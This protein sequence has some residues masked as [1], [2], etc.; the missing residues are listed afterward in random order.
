MAGKP[1]TQEMKD[2]AK[3]K[4]EAAGTAAKPRPPRATRPRARAGKDPVAEAVETIL[5][6]LSLPLMALGAANDVFLADALALEM[7]AAPL[8]EAMAEVAK[9]NPAIG[10]WL[11]KGAPATPYILLGTVLFSLGTQIAVNHGANLGPLAAQTN[12]RA[13]MVAEKKRRI[14]EIQ[15]RQEQNDKEIA[16][17]MRAAAQY[18]KETSEREAKEYAEQL[19]R[20]DAEYARRVAEDGWEPKDTPL[21]DVVI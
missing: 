7:T 13:V 19:E 3:R 10:D 5:G 21:A 12:T 6:V 8:G 2:E 4:R 11:E 15:L 20:S 1:W 16:E 18:E 9:V 17:D 14:A